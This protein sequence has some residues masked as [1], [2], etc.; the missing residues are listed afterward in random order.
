MARI[1]CDGIDAALKILNEDIHYVGV[2]Q[3]ESQA[4]PA[5]ELEET[6]CFV[7]FDESARTIALK[8]RASWPWSSAFSKYVNKKGAAENLR[9][10]RATA[11]AADIQLPPG[12]VTSELKIATADGELEIQQL[13]LLDGRVIAW[14]DFVKQ[15][16]VSPGDRFEPVAR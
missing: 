2:P 1:A 5:P 7:R 6:D 10:L 3:D 4:T 12:T 11:G 8:C 14:Q 15:R 13:A 16:Q 9:I